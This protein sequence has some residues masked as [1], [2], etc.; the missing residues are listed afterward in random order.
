ML[1]ATR[2]LAQTNKLALLARPRW[3][4]LELDLADLFARQ[5]AFSPSV[6]SGRS[7]L[8]L[9]LPILSSA[10]GL[11][12]LLFFRLPM[13]QSESLHRVGAHRAIEWARELPCANSTAPAPAPEGGPEMASKRPLRSRIVLR[14]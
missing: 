5:R 14:R 12:P 8:S 4:Q 7:G 10:H 1:V 6:E 13:K 2:Q 3:V 11:S 9:M